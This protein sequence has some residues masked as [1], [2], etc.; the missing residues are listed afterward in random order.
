MDRGGPAE[1]P[2]RPA[3]RRTA[4]AGER[5][6]APM[7][8]H[9]TDCSERRSRT[10][11]RQWRVAAYPQGGDPPPSGG[12]N[13]ATAGRKTDRNASGNRPRRRGGMPENTGQFRRRRHRR[14]PAGR[15]TCPFFIAP[16]TYRSLTPAASPKKSTG[17][18]FRVSEFAQLREVRPNPAALV[19]ATAVQA[20][21]ASSPGAFLAEIPGRSRYR[22]AVSF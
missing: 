13:A 20:P 8:P 14:P 17:R 21:S 19:R 15:A 12:G 6:V 5:G 9:V 11:T 2:K 16:E 4:F 18:P 1:K 10:S 7:P 3:R 22:P